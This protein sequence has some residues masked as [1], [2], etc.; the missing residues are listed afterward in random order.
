LFQ[1]AFYD[2][3]IILY[4]KMLFETNLMTQELVAGVT[5]E[6]CVN[7]VLSVEGRLPTVKAF[8]YLYAFVYFL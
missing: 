6:Y 8:E 5:M 1:D 4:L 3:W 7:D 2:P